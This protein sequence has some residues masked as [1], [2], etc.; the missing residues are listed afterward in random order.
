MPEL[1]EVRVVRQELNKYV[2]NRKIKEVS[3]F[4]DK[5]I[6]EIEASEFAD[7]LK[8]KTVEFVE[9]I[10][11]FLAFHF[12][13]NIVVLSHLRMEGKYNFYEPRKERLF[14]DYV[15]FEFE[16][17]TNL[18]YNDTRMF[19]TFHLRTKENYLNTLPLSKLAKIPAETDLNDFIK[20]LSKRKQ[21]IK[22]V[23]LDQT[24]VVGLG[25]IY[26]DE[27]LFATKISPLT[28]ANEITKKQA[29][30][31]LEAATD[32]LDRSTELGGS[33]INSYTSLN[34]KK[35]S[36]QNFLQVHTKKGKACPE[37]SQEIDKIKVNGR[38][39]YICRRCQ[40]VK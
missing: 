37:C 9:N 19:G 7:V 34:K 18:H 11:K 4:R 32:I 13:E 22:T 6:Q 12:S 31:I 10:G 29:K 27:V 1:P 26:V 36:F 40:N 39:T 16:D 24:I 14:H 23:L 5:F 20:S 3:I 38:G 17:N 21:A 8:G 33:S 2:Q 30:E 15:I 28:P 35:G 25:N